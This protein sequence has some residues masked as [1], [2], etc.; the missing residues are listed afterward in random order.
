MFGGMESR[1]TLSSM[2]AIERAYLICA[3]PRS[4]STLLCEL[5]KATGVAGR[6]E[7]YFETLRAT[8]VPRQPRPYFED[9]A[10]PAVLDLLSPGEPVEP[11]TAFDPAAGRRA[12]TTPNGV[13]GAKVIVES[14]RRPVAAAGRALA[15]G[16][17]PEAPL[18][19]GRA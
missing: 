6:P 8:G 4:G 5:L 15:R 1:V 10:D 12:G 14:P 7:E 13:F 19:A 3:T 2:S 11:E 9:V 18:R 16:R 17:A